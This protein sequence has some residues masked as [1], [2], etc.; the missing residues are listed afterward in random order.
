MVLN[1]LG[2]GNFSQFR[3]K[4]PISGVFLR[5]PGNLEEALPETNLAVP[6]SLIENYRS[7]T[8]YPRFIRTEERTRKSYISMFELR[9]TDAVL[10]PTK[11]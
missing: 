4:S 2:S 3:L 7:G 6:K 9:Q 8:F 1:K 11:S 5:T 10:V